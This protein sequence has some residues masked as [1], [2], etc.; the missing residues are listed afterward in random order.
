VKHAF[1]LVAVRHGRTAW[2][3]DGRFQGHTDNALDHS[4]RAQARAL[5]LAFAAED[6]DFAISSDLCRARET[7]EIILAGR[8]R[9]IE[10]D[11]RWREMRF[12]AWEGLTWSEIVARDPAL[13]EASSTTPKTYTPDGGESF[14][15]VCERVAAAVASIDARAHDGANVIVTT[16]AGPLHALLRVILGETEAVALG[17]KFSPASYSRFSLGPRGGHVVALNVTVEQAAT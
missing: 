16:H 8:T 6:F 3:A 9:A 10:R 7:A 4:G 11:V 1:Q 2:N 13:A 14:D 15:E 17:V 12:G 5:A